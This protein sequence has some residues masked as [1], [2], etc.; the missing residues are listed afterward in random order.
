MPVAVRAPC[1]AQPGCPE[2]NMLCS[3]SLRP[4]PSQP[5]N[6]FVRAAMCLCWIG[7]REWRM[8]QRDKLR[9]EFDAGPQGPLD[10][11]IDTDDI[12]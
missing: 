6:L 12:K 4:V 9:E 2:Q 11:E 8:R 1:N 7:R 10:W 5:T 3:V